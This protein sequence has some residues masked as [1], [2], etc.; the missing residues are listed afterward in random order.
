MNP[1]RMPHEFMLTIFISSYH[2]IIKLTPTLPSP[3][4]YL[5][6]SPNSNGPPTPKLALRPLE[7][8]FQHR[9]PPPLHS[10][11]C[12]RQQFRQFVRRRSHPGPA[13]VARRRRSYTTIIRGWRETDVELFVGGPRS[14]AVG[15][16]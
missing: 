3:L 14:D 4:V 12:F 1:C 6:T 11:H 15:V 2:T 9:T 7:L 10:F 5:H 16:D 13:L 8:R